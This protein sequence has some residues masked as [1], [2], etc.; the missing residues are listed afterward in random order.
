MAISEVSSGGSP[1]LQQPELDARMPKALAHH[2]RVTGLDVRVDRVGAGQPLVFLNG[3]LGLNEHW[4]GCLRYLVGP[5]VKGGIECLFIE[6]PL[7]ELRGPGCSVEG[8]TN[9]TVNLLEMLVD[10][11]AVLVGNSLG[12]HVALKI[13]MARPDLVQ[14][15]VLVGSSGLFERSFEKD[16]PRNPTREWM[17]HKIGGLFDDPS[18]MI[19]GMVDMAHEALSRRTAVRSI[20]RLGKSAK[21]DH[22]GDQLHKV[23]V[24]VLLAWGKQDTVTPPEV[25]EQ[26]AELLPDARLRWIDRCGHAPQIERP[27]ELCGHVRAFFRELAGSVHGGQAGVA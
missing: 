20:V 15:L 27:E 17:E 4:F 18:R 9:L 3:L 5:E 24:P 25:A 23:R 7:L 1:A 8:V 12:G 19:P 10:E 13:A 2:H 11:P 22:L 16:V 14:G 26:F 6:P 21:R